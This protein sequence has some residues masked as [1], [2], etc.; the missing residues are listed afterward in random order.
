MAVEDEIPM[1]VTSL[2]EARRKRS[3]E[4]GR[5]SKDHGLALTLL[6]FSLMRLPTYWFV[7]P[8]TL[9]LPLPRYRWRTAIGEGKGLS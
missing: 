1:A 9:W 6:I 8:V 7:F 4:G 3:F 5:L 2:R